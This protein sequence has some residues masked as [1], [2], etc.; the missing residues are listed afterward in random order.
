MAKTDKP[1]PS[2]KN[3]SENLSEIRKTIVVGHL[4]TE[5]SDTLDF[6]EPIIMKTDQFKVERYSAE[7]FKLIKARP[8]TPLIIVL[9]SL[10]QDATII[11]V[12]YFSAL[13]AGLWYNIINLTPEE[14]KQF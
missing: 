8:K 11:Q 2:K 14:L 5:K 10:E 6:E 1:K 12:G 13:E 9:D 4:G 3:G 7:F